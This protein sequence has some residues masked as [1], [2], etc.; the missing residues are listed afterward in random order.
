MSIE[1][2]STERTIEDLG[3]EF[4]EAIADL[5]EYRAFLEAKEV[6]EADEEAQKQI[7]EFERARR[8]Y[9][10]ARE[11]GQASRDDLREMQQKQEELHEIPVMKEFLQAENDLELRLQ[12]LNEHVNE[13]LEIDFG[14]KASGCCND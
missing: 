7:A 1:T 3:R 5:P 2:E 9:M 6:V 10:D 11:R 12:A 4:G 13:P 14:D 8:R